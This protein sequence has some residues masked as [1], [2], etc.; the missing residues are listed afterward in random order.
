MRKYIILIAAVLIQLCLGASYSWSTFVPA[1]KQNYG[2]SITQTQ[3]IFG[4]ISFTITI[5]IF[6]G[7]RIQDRIGPRI[8]S[9]IGGIIFGASYIL[10]G[11]SSGSYPTLFSLI[12][13]GSGVGA[14]LCYLCPIACAMKWFP[15]H[16]SLVTGI[17]VAG[18]GGSAIIISRLGENLL[19]QNVSVLE[20]FKYL[21][22]GFLIIVTLSA[23]FLENPPQEENTFGSAKIRTIDVLHDRYFWGLFCGIFPCQCIGLMVIGNIKPYGLS[24][25][26]SLAAAGAAVSI[27]AIFNA[28]GRICWGILGGLAPGKNIILIS[29]ISTSLVC[30]TMPL[31]ITGS[32]SFQIFATLAGFNY[33]ACL[34]LYAA[35]VAH[36]YGTE[37]MGTVYS[38]LFLSNAVAAIIGPPLAGKIFDMTGSYTPAFLVFGCLSFVAIFLFYVIYQPDRLQ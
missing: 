36:H 2:F 38:T 32:T 30:L 23:L 25:N 6:F 9:V 16:K 35:E 26:L 29:L 34:V 5:L 10:A 7:G 24:L 4:A 12:G 20:I 37:Q 18:F 1:L 17:A 8:P 19:A 33:G 14:G 13:I 28:A 21:G 31:V 22:V 27:I 11:F 15:N 3:T